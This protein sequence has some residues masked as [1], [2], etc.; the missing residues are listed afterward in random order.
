[1]K[2]PFTLEDIE[3]AA[4][5]LDAKL[6]IG[7]TVYVR[8]AAEELWRSAIIRKAIRRPAHGMAMAVYHPSYV[9]DVP[10]DE[11]PDGPGYSAEGKS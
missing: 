8:L 1:M 6:G 10:N 4:N 5:R 2:H 9:F 3:A 11:N 7:S